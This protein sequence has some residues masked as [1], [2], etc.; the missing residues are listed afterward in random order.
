V[1]THVTSFTEESQVWESHVSM[2]QDI[3]SVPYRT[4]LNVFL[5]VAVVIVKSEMTVW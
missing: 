4:D 1:T 5:N 3:K 2:Q